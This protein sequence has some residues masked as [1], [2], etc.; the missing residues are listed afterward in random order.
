MKVD[1]V[2]FLCFFAAAFIMGAAVNANAISITPDTNPTDLV[3]VILGPGVSLVGV[4]TFTGGANQ[5]GTFIA[6]APE[7]GFA[8]GIVL[9]S[10]DVTQ[11]PG[12]NSNAGSGF[13]ETIGV[14]DTDDDDLNVSVGT[15]GDPDVTAV[16][17]VGTLDASV[18]EFGFQFG[19]GTSVDNSL[20]F[21]FVFGS[22]EYVDWIDSAW[23]DAFVFLLDGT[24]NLAVIGTDPISINTVNNTQKSANYINN[25]GNTDGLPVA[26]L[27]IKFDGLTTV[28]QAQAT[29]IGA[30]THTIKLAVA[31]A[32]DSQLD[33]G[34]F[35]QKGSFSSIPE[36]S[37]LL[38]IGTGLIGLAG[39]RRNFRK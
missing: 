30:G 7:V 27:G 29:G 21:N 23:N 1:K 33:S 19:D 39:F 4:P 38:L 11:I 14:G 3:N 37:T 28:L 2:F 35:I 25:V 22:E 12:P 31:D 6:G 34:V 18:L 13:P 24:T 15:A 9:H 5:A 32:N 17:G 10:G 26:G 16:A 8:S 20:S 36:P